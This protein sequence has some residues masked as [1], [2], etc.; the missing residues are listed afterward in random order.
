[1][2]ERIY[3]MD[4][5]GVTES[6]REDVDYDRIDGSLFIGVPAKLLY[7]KSVMRLSKYVHWRYIC[8]GR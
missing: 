2:N 8:V 6:I 1:M 7:S 4:W 3:K 5:E